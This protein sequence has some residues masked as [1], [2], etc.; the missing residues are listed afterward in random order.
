MPESWIY[1]GNDKATCQL[2]IRGAQRETVFK[3]TQGKV[4]KGVFN[5]NHRE[6][7][8]AARKVSFVY[9]R[10]V[11]CWMAQE[12]I[13]RTER[14]IACKPHR[15][16]KRCTPKRNKDVISRKKNANLIAYELRLSIWILEKYEWNDKRKK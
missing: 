1:R 13:P 6:K 2:L 9:W 5:G 12:E 4:Q 3:G 7:S 15:K 16:R 8:E 11:D 10:N 14:N